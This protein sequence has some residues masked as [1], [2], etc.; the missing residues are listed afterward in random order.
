MVKTVLGKSTLGKI[1]SGLEKP[2]KGQVTI[3]NISTANKKEFLNIRKKV[4]VVFQNPENQILFNNVYD[5]IA[6]T[7]KNLGITDI[8][9]KIEVS[10]DKLNMKEFLNKEAYN[11]SLGQKQRVTISGVIATN[12]KYIVLDEPTAMLDS[13]GKE[14]VCNMVKDLKKQG[15]T[16]IYITNVMSEILMSDKIIVIEEGE[17]IKQFAKENLLEEIDFLR[18]HG[19]KIS[20][21]VELIYELK[22]NGIDMQIENWDKDEIIRKIINIVGTDGVSCSKNRGEGTIEKCS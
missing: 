22:N 11:L 15:Y 7:M 13:K 5:D 16:I 6:F 4:G 19:I 10:L 1:I 21:F 9:E 20:D 3:D 8:K 12:P 18:E 17:I 2:T 14:D